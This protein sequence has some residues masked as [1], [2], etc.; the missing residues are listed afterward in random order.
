[1]I[2]WGP[3][4]TEVCPPSADLVKQD[5]FFP[6]YM[7]SRSKFENAAVHTRSPPFFMIVFQYGITRGKIHGCGHALNVDGNVWL[8]IIAWPVAGIFWSKK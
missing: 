4:E 8:S 6:R 2:V 5:R 1:M 7:V 3:W